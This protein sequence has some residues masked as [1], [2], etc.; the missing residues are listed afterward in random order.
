M[1]TLLI[2]DLHLSPERPAV[3]RAFFAFLENHADDIK[4]LYILGDLFEA[5]VGD[6]DPAPLARQVIA[7]LKK[8]SDSGVRLFFTH[9]NRDFLIGK[10]FARESGATLLPDHHL[11]ELGGQR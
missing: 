3:T 1:T 4:A 7:A 9:G 2:S 10:Q 8:L 11:A 5:W 6:D